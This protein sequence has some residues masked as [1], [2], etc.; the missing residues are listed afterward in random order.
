MSD[1]S[2]HPLAP[3]VP[4]PAA[5]KAP[6]APPS[7]LR[8]SRRR[9]ELMLPGRRADLRRLRAA[10]LSRDRWVRAYWL[11]ARKVVDP[12]GLPETPK[13]MRHPGA[14]VHAAAARAARQ[15]AL[16]TFAERLARGESLLDAHLATVRALLTVKD[17]ATARAITLGIAGHDADETLL[18]RR[19]GMGLVLGHL[20]Y[21]EL[22]WRDLSRVDD[23][24]LALRVPL[25]A[26]QSALVCRDPRAVSVSRL[27]ASRGLDPDPDLLCELAGRMLVVGETELF[28]Q[29]LDAAEG[30]SPEEGTAAG[31]KLHN[32]QRW[33]RPRPVPP[34]SSEADVVRFGVLDYYQ[35]DFERSSR[36][37]GDYVQTLAMLSHLARFT[38]VDFHGGD[39]LGQLVTELQARVPTGL[40]SAVGE[41]S[42]GRPGR[43]VELVAVSRDF[44][45]GDVIAPDTWM[46][47]FGWHLHT[48]FELGYGLPYHP[49]L[50]PVFVSFHLNKVE[51]LTP[52][53]IDYLAAHGPI[54]CRDWTTVDLL[55]SAG[56][57]AFFT[58]CVT[59]TVGGVFAPPAE[60]DRSRAR[61]VGLVDVSPRAAGITTEPYELVTHAEFRVRQLDLV[62]GLREA[63]GLLEGYQRRFSRIV[64]NRL[65]SYLPATSLGLDVTFLPPRAGDVRFEGLMG[66][67]PNAPEFV[68]MRDSI[69]ALLAE[70]LA[71]IMGGATREEVYARWRERTAPLVEQARARLAMPGTT[72]SLDPWEAIAAVRRHARVYGP[73]SDVRSG[74]VTDVA[75]SLDA[76]LSDILPVT[77]E[78]L[79]ANAGGPLRLWITTRGIDEEYQRWVAEA[80]PQVPITF[81]PFDAVGHGEIRRMIRHIS[82]ATMDR[83]L[84]P[85]LLDDV[86]RLV[87]V[88]IDTVTEGDVCALGAIDLRGHPVAAR[89]TMH[90]GPTIW[91]N[92]GD[93][94]DHDEASELRRLMAARHAPGYRTFNAGVLVLD[95]ARMRKD[96]FVADL[97]PLAYR[98]GLHDQDLLLAYCGH[99]RLELPSH[100]NALPLLEDI[101][102]PGIVHYAGAG[103]PWGGPLVP[104]REIWSRWA[105]RSRERVGE[106]PRP[107]AADAGGDG[108]P[109]PP[110][111]EITGPAAAV[112]PVTTD[113]EV[114]VG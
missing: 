86:D 80:F 60:T 87:Y 12:A 104:G 66:M 7:L 77:L 10:R 8:R 99:D 41:V 21:H 68:H 9:V 105:A 33:R 6:K 100:W 81:L 64:T 44:S 72:V 96:R 74:E 40:R 98:F 93:L 84:L 3:S 26:V 57:D 22:A 109:G 49:H 16:S 89:T 71:Q 34:A 48:T 19:L 62:Q 102:E 73:L 1:V 42:E 79:V 35:P 94:H 67:S 23:E 31:N 14:R 36:N 13:G 37:V 27:V 85:E 97:L 83:L 113:V 25:E 20:G 78:S 95:L 46:V 30:C 107:V 90:D 76:N 65:H 24:T 45:E 18:A 101:T 82:V 53:T 112:P 75:L 91:R 54:G 32:L 11:L 17:R 38:D 5:P 43:R 39:G 108:P 70:P 4:A 58:G 69:R 106:P 61:T 52:E 15:K 47:A 50:N 56:V 28:G 88:D 103:K 55:L 114:A 51:A 63:L 92:V 29:L 110:L 111:E 59:T 2:G